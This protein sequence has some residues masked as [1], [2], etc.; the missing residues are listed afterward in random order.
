MSKVVLTP[1]ALTA[2]LDP[3]AVASTLDSAGSA[4][5]VAA[6]SMEAAASTV[7]NLTCELFASLHE[8]SV[9]SAANVTGHSDCPFGRLTGPSLYE[10][11][12][13][14]VI[15]PNTT[16]RWALNIPWNRCS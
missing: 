4:L 5:H 2:D 7:A 8:S 10:S 15:C 6:R 3:E 12:P 16:Q 14:A 11:F 13:P 1:A 9:G